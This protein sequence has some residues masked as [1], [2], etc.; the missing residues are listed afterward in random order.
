MLRPICIPPYA[1]ISLFNVYPLVDI[2]WIE[3]RRSYKRKPW[4]DLP[5]E[6]LTQ[7]L[8]AI[9]IVI[10]GTGKCFPLDVSEEAIRVVG[11]VK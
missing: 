1:Y 11:H 8:D 9:R 10:E 7:D 2:E 3:F 5:T 4:D 6:T